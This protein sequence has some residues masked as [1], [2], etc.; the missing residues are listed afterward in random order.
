ML[1]CTGFMDETIRQTKT[2]RLVIRAAHRRGSIRA[3][4]FTSI[5]HTLGATCLLGGTLQLYAISQGA[6]D[7]FLGLLA[8]AVWMGAPFLLIGM[9]L[10]RRYGKRRILILWTGIL[11]AVSLAIVV[12]LPFVGHM[13]WLSNRLILYL[14]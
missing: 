12:V 3:A 11:P 6:D 5:T 1:K 8:C 13:G 9:S 7:L 14:L 10:M 4:I 2:G